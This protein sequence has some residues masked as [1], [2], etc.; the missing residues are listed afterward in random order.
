MS[1]SSQPLLLLTG[2]TGYVGG[3]LL[4]ALTARGYRLRCLARRPEFLAA[5]VGPNTT[6]V[7]G[8]V[9]DASSLPAAFAGMHAAYYLVHSMGSNGTFEEQDRRAACNFAEAARRAGVQRLIYL[10]GLG[11]GRALSPHLASRH[12]VG[13]LLQ[14]SGVPTV[15]LRASII[16]GS[17]SLSFEMIRALV[18]KLPVMITPR[19]TRSLA[20]PIAIEDVIDYLIAALEVPATGVF[21]IGGADQVSYLDL[22]K[23]YARQRGLRRLIIPV[24]VLT[25]RLSSLWLGLVTPLYA[26]VGRKLIDSV[27]HDTVVT[28]RRSLT[29]F[30][31]QPRGIRAAIARA[32]A[33]EDREFAQTRWSDALSS[34]GQPRSWGG[35]KFGTR[36]V[37]SRSLQV[38][39]SPSAAMAAI[40]RIG[41]ATGWY[42][43]NWLWR[44][45]GFIDLLFG[46]VGLRR[47]RR[48]PEW[49]VPGDTVDF[50]RVEAFEPDRLLR[51]HAEMK[52]PGRAWLQ[53]EVEPAVS[54]ASIRQTAIFDPAG[55]IGLLYWYVLYP[56]HELVFAGMLRGL[57]RA[58]KM[59]GQ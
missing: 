38:P 33:N 58:I 23:E 31:I 2:A 50:W 47:G 3:R 51:L 9:L 21:E 53:F 39:C 46:G 41:G 16:I 29:T 55:V 48:D 22:M 56:V 18:E 26:R 19:W 10:G 1:G 25:P 17:G 15:E 7:K 8:D 59:E 57:V 24:P 34:P 45:R 14:K 5:R 28:D 35:V 13:R 43:C 42:C 11:N 52:L 49:L 54:G 27:R 36:V 32:L 6:I 12:E 30:A 40:R 4:Q 20:Q 37:D 44:L